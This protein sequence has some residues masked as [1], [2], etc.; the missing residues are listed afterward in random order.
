MVEYLFFAL[1]IFIA[2]LLFQHI[3]GPIM[4]YQSEEVPFRYQFN[5]IDSDSFMDD[6]N[7]RFKEDH[8]RLLSL[9]F[10]Y[11]GSS[12]LAKTNATMF[13]SLYSLDDEALAATLVT[14]IS[15]AGE[16]NYLEFTQVYAD[17]SCLSVCNS[18]M[19]STYPKMV[20]KL[21][22]RFPGIIDCLELL[23]VFRLV[24]ARYSS[25]KTP[26]GFVNGKEF[27]A[28]ENYLNEELNYLIENGYY[29]D[30][31]VDGKFKLTI[32]GALLFTWKNLWPWKN[33]ISMLEIRAAKKA[34]S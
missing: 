20:N 12:R 17:R 15:G 9:G 19:I 24:K 27:R 1:Y 5:L 3:L 23:E 18:P 7:D 14:G 6:R 22:F 33:I 13:F 10:R 16:M 31:P 26:L 29:S 21:F 8:E 32:K 34:V 4:V 28:V 30:E 25:G 11:V 2:Y